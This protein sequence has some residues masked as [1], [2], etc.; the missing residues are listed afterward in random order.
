MGPSLGGYLTDSYSWRWVFYINVPFGILAFLGI[1]KFGKDSNKKST[2][3]DFIGFSLFAIFIASLQLML[4][5]GNQL[6]WFYS[7][8]IKIYLFTMLSTLWMFC[9]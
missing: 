8:E 9:Y 5:R 1:L 7:T 4:D 3:F 6:D 2:P